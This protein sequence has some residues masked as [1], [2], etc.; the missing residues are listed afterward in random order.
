MSPDLMKQRDDLLLL[1]SSLMAYPGNDYPEKIAH[2]IAQARAFPPIQEILKTFS[3]WCETQTRAELEENYTATFE[4]QGRYCLDIGFVLFGEDY[5]RGEFLVN[6]QRICREHNVDV[7][8]ELPD[9]LPTVLRLLHKLDASERKELT[10]KIV[11]PA[12]Q[13]IMGPSA[14]WETINP[15]VRTVRCVSILLELDCIMDNKVL[16]EAT[17]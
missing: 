9:H 12:L 17:C 3:A 2:A 11:L 16:E 4:I 15:F 1:L 14:N 5:K 10:A 6:M 7:G 13:K 8:S